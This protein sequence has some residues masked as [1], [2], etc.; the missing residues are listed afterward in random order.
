MLSAIVRVSRV[1]RRDVVRQHVRLGRDEQDVV[2]GEPFLGEL[3]RASE[4]REPSSTWPSGSFSQRAFDGRG[5]AADRLVGSGLRRDSATGASSVTSTDPAAGPPGAGRSGRRRSRAPTLRRRRPRAAASPRRAARVLRAARN[6]ASRT[7]P[8]PTADT[9]SS[10]G[11]TAR[12]RR[13]AVSSRRSATQP[14]VV[15]DQDVAR[16]HARDAVERELEVLVVVQLLPDEALG[17][18][19]VRRDDRRPALDAEPQRLAV[20]VEHRP[21][22]APVQHRGSPRSR[23]AVD[24]RAAASRRRR[25]TRRRARGSRASRAGSRARPRRPRAPLVDLG[26][27]VAGRVDDRRRRP[28]LAGDPDEVVEDPLRLSSSTIRVPVRP[29]A[30]PGR[31]DRDAELLERPR[32][33]E[34]L[35]P[36]SVTAALARWR[37]PSWKFGTVSVR[38]TAALS[39]TVTIMTPTHVSHDQ[40][41]R[42]ARP[43]VQPTR[44]AT[45]GLLDRAGGDERAPGDH[46]AAGRDGD[47]AEPLALADRQ[48]DGHRRDDAL[49]ERPADP[50]DAPRRLG[51]DERDGGAAVRERDR[52]VDAPRLR[53]LDDDVLREPP[54]EQR[55]RGRCCAR[56]GR[57]SRGSSRRSSCPGRARPR[58]AT[59]RRPTCGRS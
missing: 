16:A 53:R 5:C 28:R 47:D 34:P 10:G 36:A 32:D 22:A 59:S 23:T 54:R 9:G 38:S 58:P 31:D 4:R 49:H 41:W 8:E 17:L 27:R 35:P 15:R 45:A 37:W 13:S 55:A 24:A 11:V 29:P 48:L 20:G 46:A 26:V 42:A 12:K 19:L 6:A 56:N 33:V 57:A 21:H 44:A 51:R 52:R 30:R 3:L 18:A 1:A 25:R 40:A 2:E 7:S 43:R 50:D 39:V 14:V